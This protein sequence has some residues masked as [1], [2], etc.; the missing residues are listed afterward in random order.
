MRKLLLG[1]GVITLAAL[2]VAAAED[3]PFAQEIKARQGLMEINALNISI[4]YNMSKGNLPFDQAQAQ[5]AAAALV[6]VYNLDLPM[7]WPEGSDTGANPNSRAKPEIWGKS[8]DIGAKTWEIN[9][10][11][12]GSCVAE[13]E[14]R[15]RRR[16]ISCR[17]NRASTCC[18]S[19]RFDCKL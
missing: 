9:S 18:I 19:C 15:F 16:V 5:A 10:P 2:G 13:F 6:G 8:A 14:W 1:I 11:K 7:L 3:A 4:L 12:G 17:W